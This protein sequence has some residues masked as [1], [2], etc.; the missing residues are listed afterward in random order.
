MAQKALTEMQETL[1]MRYEGL[2]GTIMPNALTCKKIVAGN[3][4][5]A[6][7]HKKA[8]AIIRTYGC[9]MRIE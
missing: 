6:R 4:G 5:T 3:S 7:A 9:T 1:K 8:Y 2:R